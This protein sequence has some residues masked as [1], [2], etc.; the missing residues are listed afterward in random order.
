M[1]TRG[2]DSVI[3]HLRRVVLD[4]TSDEELLTAIT[5]RRTLISLSPSTSATA[6]Q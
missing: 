3:R 1:K 2:L 5:T 6:A 4:T